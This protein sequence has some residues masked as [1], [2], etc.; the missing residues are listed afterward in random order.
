M[1]YLGNLPSK[2]VWTLATS[3]LIGSVTLTCAAQSS[4]EILNKTTAEVKVFLDE[5]SDVKCTEH[6]TQ[7]K[8]N[9][10]GKIQ[11]R[12]D[13]TFDYL[14]IMQAGDDDLLMNES[15]LPMQ[16]VKAKAKNV[17]FL[18][19]NGFSTLFLIFHPYY[20]DSFKLTPDG[21]EVINKKVQWRIRFEHIPGTRTPA[22][23]A[24]RGREY[25]LEL[26]GVAWID[27]DTGDITRIEAGL[28]NSME[29]VG[30][31][32]LVTTVDYSPVKLPGLE[33]NYLFP[34]RATVEVESLRQH[35]INTHTFSEYK[36][37]SVSTD[38]A[39]SEKKN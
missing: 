30:L 37:F 31:K 6:V 4:D 19:T 13:S 32:K 29:D 10:N 21:T 9:P 1:K 22:A 17:P 18:I 2:L 26:A 12:Q 28:A 7:E 39:I 20:R 35:W 36:R 11:Y 3:V 16:E 23:L 8:L 15:R 33:R 38:V 24:V 34:L 14:I 25:P 27:P 5:L